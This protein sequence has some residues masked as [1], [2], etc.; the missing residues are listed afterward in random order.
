MATLRLS[1]DCH[2]T[3]R[4]WMEVGRQSPF[5]RVYDHSLPHSQLATSDVE[6]EWRTRALSVQA[7]PLEP[8]L[9][10][11]PRL[12]FRPLAG[13]ASRRRSMKWVIKSSPAA[14]T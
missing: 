12:C 5:S 3:E 4:S 1:S 7:K 6:G 8:L 13:L 2:L 10:A 9:A 14:V 11:T